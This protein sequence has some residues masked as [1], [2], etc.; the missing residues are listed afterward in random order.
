MGEKLTINYLAD[1]EEEGENENN[2]EESTRTRERMA[3]LLDHWG[4]EC[5]CTRC[6]S[7]NVNEL[8]RIDL[9]VDSKVRKEANPGDSPASISQSQTTCV[10]GVGQD[11]DDEKDGSNSKRRK[12]EEE[13][14]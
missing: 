10:D 14:Q 5:N 4:F 6:V 3:V 2:V 7:V 11:G 1:R 13:N 8:G 9:G 12:L